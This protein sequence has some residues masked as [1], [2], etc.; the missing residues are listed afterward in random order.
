MKQNRALKLAYMA[1]FF[2]G[3]GY[4]GIA[5]MKKGDFSPYHQLVV[6]LSQKDG[7]VMDW[8]IGN[9]GGSAS[10]ITKAR[11]YNWRLS[12][13][14]AYDFLKEIYP[15]LKYKKPQ[16]EIAMRYQERL[17]K[18]NRPW[19]RTRVSPHELAIRESYYE[20]LKE[21]KKTVSPSIVVDVRGAG[22]TTKRD[23]LRQQDAIV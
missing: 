10:R 20:K 9:F 15:F 23:D 12:A 16:A 22:E 13:R 8:I 6:T 1:G 17:M 19:G 21:L 5:K 14:K 7:A 2:D 3:E 4:V 18:Q 11:I